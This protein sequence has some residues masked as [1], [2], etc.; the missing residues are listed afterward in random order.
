MLNPKSWN[1]LKEAASAA[2]LAL[3]VALVAGIALGVL[4]A[5]PPAWRCLKMEIPSA[6]RAA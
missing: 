4:G 3:A 6:L 5:L 1:G 2:I